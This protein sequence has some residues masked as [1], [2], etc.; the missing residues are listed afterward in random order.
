MKRNIIW[1]LA[2]IIAIFFLFLLW[3]YPMGAASAGNQQERRAGPRRR[4][5]TRADEVTKIARDPSKV[6]LQIAARS[7][8]DRNS[9]RQFGAIMEDYGTMVI[10]AATAQAAQAARQNTSLDVSTLETTIELR[11][12]R[13]DPLLNDP[14]KQYEATSGYRE[15]AESE[16][17]YYLV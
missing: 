7:E 6:I 12:F 17:D 8:A 4:V 1:M 9:A 10:V 2:A 15:S 11:G 16:G 3:N 13:F 14:A 5:N